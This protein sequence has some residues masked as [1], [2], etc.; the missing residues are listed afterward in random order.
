MR[1][2]LAEIIC[3]NCNYHTYIKSHTLVKPQLEPE[4]TKRILQGNMFTYECP[5]CHTMISFIH[6]FLYH[7]NECKLLIGMDLKDQTIAALKEQLPDSDLYLVDDPIQLSETIRITKDHFCIDVIQQVKYQLCKQDKNIQK[8]SYFDFDRT[9][10]MLWF[11][12]KYQQYEQYKA[13]SYSAYQKIKQ[14]IGK[15]GTKDE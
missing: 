2:I 8:I 9:N 4:L 10:Q 3:R 7:D 15:E 14:G 6:S 1:H 11:T 12:C 5:R 13:V